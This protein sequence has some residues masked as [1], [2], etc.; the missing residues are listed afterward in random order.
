[1]PYTIVRQVSFRGESL[2][3]SVEIPGDELHIGRGISIDLRLDDLAVYLKQAVIRKDI[4][5]GY[6][7]QD[8]T[9]AG[10]IYLNRI[11]ITQAVL[12]SGDTLRIQEYLISVSLSDLTDS[13][14]LRVT[15]ET[16][17]EAEPSLA[18]M[19]RFQLSE[20][21]WTK[22]L[23]TIFLVLFVLVGSAVAGA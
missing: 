6:V 3:R 14:V 13:L 9:Q 1:M 2:E 22:R 18:L 21:R 19:P 16:Q 11:P 20:G 7:I 10:G 15:Q 4:E 8:L 17:G 23:L 5:Q 12:H